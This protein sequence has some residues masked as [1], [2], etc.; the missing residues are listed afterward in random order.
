MN[1]ER[2]RY[3]L[4][5]EHLVLAALSLALWGRLAA[6][7]D[8]PEPLRPPV[9]SESPRIDGNLD[10]AVW[11]GALVIDD[12]V[13]RQPREGDPPSERTEVRV[14]YTP[15]DLYL[16]FRAFD[17]RPD[18]IVA[19]ARKR[20][21]FG[22]V[23]NDQFALAI[24]SYDDG[25]NG[26][27]FSTNPLGVRV[28]AQFF[29][30]GER[31]IGDWN[32][33]WDCASRVDEHGW[34][35]EMRI[36]FST[37]RF[38]AGRQNVMGLNLYRR[39]VRTSEGLFA[40]LIPLS[41]AQGTPNVSI[42]R[43]MAFRGLVRGRELWLRPYALGGIAREGDGFGSASHT[44]RSEIG[45]DVTWTATPSLTGTLTV[46]TDFA[47]TELDDR[48]INLTRYDLFFPEKRAFFLETGGLFAMGIPEELEVFFSRRIGLEA[49]ADGRTRAAPILAGAKLSGRA[50]VLEVGALDVVTEAT[51]S[52]PAENFVV[53]RTKRGIGG[54]SYVGLIGTH[55]VSGGRFSN[56]ALGADATV[57]LVGQVGATGFLAVTRDQDAVPHDA[58]YGLTLFKGGERST[59]E[60]GYL[61]V[62]RGFHPEIGFV[63]RPGI[64][65]L[66][67][68]VRLPWYF[69]DEPLRRLTPLYVG[70]HVRGIDGFVE[71]WSHEV[72]LEAETRQEDF[73]A[74]TG[75]LRLDR[76]AAAF[77]IFRSVVIPKGSYETAWLGGTVRTK[78][79]RRISGEVTLRAGGLYDGHERT[80]GGRVSLK[81]S[82]S[83]TAAA[84]WTS[85]WIRRRKESF[86]T[87]V[88]Q[89]RVDYARDTH[90]S[91]SGLA[92]Y[93][94][95]SRDLGL[96][97]R[98]R[99][100]LREGT[101]LALVYSEVADRDA[102]L[103][104]ERPF[105]RQAD[106]S[107]IVKLTCLFALRAP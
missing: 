18:A 82:R 66:N 27:W 48:Q 58:A 85:S 54:R 78:P 84:R 70:E 49:A 86:R 35:S 53:L 72:G 87:E 57:Y 64:R 94:N 52:R 101:A 24:D 4:G 6:A 81:A 77:P 44:R 47:L 62:G 59:F 43:K 96:D 71:G 42:A 11:Q 34:T 8:S 51:A 93:D 83:L 75:G 45:G 16:A 10:E 17:S 29:E 105:G 67:G 26:F 102:V 3:H 104:P 103:G 79:G 41:Y 91:A 9:A 98:L 92:Q 100:E 69:R 30:E 107:L 99:Y 22:I 23:E 74:V 7:G 40:P 61:D 46:N 97:L 2:W 15:T 50:G 21:D 1:G 55:K 33:I 89:A 76:V 63:R 20:D 19:T 14:L 31:W 68:D 13:Q 36:P 106:R 95:A 25:R 90:L 12:F 80:A 5:H 65:R 28:D 39:I 56:A 32:G 88:V 60:L 38:K 73:L 37:L